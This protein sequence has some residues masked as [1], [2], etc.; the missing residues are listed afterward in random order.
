MHINQRFS[1]FRLLSW[2]NLFSI[3]TNIVY[4]FPLIWWFKCISNQ[5]NDESQLELNFRAKY[6]PDSCFKYALTQYIY[7]KM[8]DY[9]KWET[10]KKSKTCL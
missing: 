10:F 3:Y 5:E 1:A 6:Q 8:Y 2:K 7:D 9:S 4:I